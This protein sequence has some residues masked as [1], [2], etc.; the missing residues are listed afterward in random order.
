MICK[1]QREKDLISYYNQHLISWSWLQF[2]GY[3]ATFF[4]DVGVDPTKLKS[5][6]DL[7]CGI[8][9]F[10]TYLSEDIEYTG[11]DYSQ[12]R[13]DH[14]KATMW[15]WLTPN[16]NFFCDDIHTFVENTDM[17]QFELVNMIETLEH[18]QDPKSLI[19][20]IRE[21]NKDIIIIGTI[22]I[23]NIDKVHLQVW[24]T[25]QELECDLSPDIAI[26]CGGED[27]SDR[28]GLPGRSWNVRWN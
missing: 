25:L 11:V 5:V 20:K 15:E 9:K 17:K 26:P 10:S 8:G 16:R 21:K 28:S 13:V 19:D 27:G 18:L 22:P 4:D 7:G 12:A 24:K 2:P 3:M 23:H 6:L 1:Y 14:A